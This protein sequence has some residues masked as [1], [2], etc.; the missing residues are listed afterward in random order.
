M[1]S[2][3]SRPCWIDA[4]DEVALAAGVLAERA[5][6]L[7]VAQPLQDDLRAVVRRDPA[8]AVGGVVVLA[9]RLAVLVDLLRRA[10]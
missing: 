10:R 5:L 4:A 3:G 6:V 8:E 1:T 7:G 2:R 9:E